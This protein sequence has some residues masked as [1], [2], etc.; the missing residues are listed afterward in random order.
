MSLSGERVW[1]RRAAE[2]W[3]RCKKRENAVNELWSSIIMSFCD[4]STPYYETDHLSL[5]IPEAQSLHCFS[6]DIGLVVPIAAICSHPQSDKNP[7]H[8]KSAFILFSDDT[9][10]SWRFLSQEMRLIDRSANPDWLILQWYRDSYKPIYIYILMD[11]FSS[12]ITNILGRTESVVSN[13]H[14]SLFLCLS[15]MLTQQENK[16][17][18]IVFSLL[19]EFDHDRNDNHE[20]AVKV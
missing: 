11:W 12:D 17:R 7:P 20:E 2:E 6:S 1:C 3:N 10:N 14:F 19:F 9:R 16:Q 13:I 8:I 5:V 18:N 15:K 4:W